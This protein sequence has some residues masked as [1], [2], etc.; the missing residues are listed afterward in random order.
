MR[1]RNGLKNL[2]SFFWI[3]Q[4]AFASGYVAT[5]SDFSFV[6]YVVGRSVVKSLVRAFLVQLVQVVGDALPWARLRSRSKP[7]DFFLLGVAP[8][9]LHVHVVEPA[10]LAVHGD[11]YAAHL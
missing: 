1:Q 4:C 3:F 9:V 6:E 2:D 10:A 8:Q 7:V 5:G 11:A